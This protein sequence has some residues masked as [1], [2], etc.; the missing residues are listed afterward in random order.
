MLIGDRIRAIREAKNL[1]QGEIFKRS[2][3]RAAYVSRVE[4]GHTAPSVDTLEKFAAALEVPLYQ[5]VY[6][7]KKRPLPPRLPKRKR[8]AEITW[9][10]TRK[11]IYFWTRSGDCLRAWANPTGGFCSTWPG[12]WR[13]RKIPP[14]TIPN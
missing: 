8:A 1:T 9:G 5:L 10:T 12:R 14:I 7:G 6:E 11:E 13:S 2:G 4:H 3:L